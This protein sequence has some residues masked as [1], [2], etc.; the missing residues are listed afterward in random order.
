MVIR[1][2]PLNGARL[3][4]VNGLPVDEADEVRIATVEHWG[5]PDSAVYLDFRMAPSMP[6]LEF[7]VVEH[8]LRPEELL[9]EEAFARPPEYAPDIVRWSDRALLRT[10]VRL[11]LERGAVNSWRPT[12]GATVEDSPPAAGEPG[13]ADTIDAA[14]PAGGDTVSQD[15]AADTVR[16]PLPADSVLQRRPA[17]AAPGLGSPCPAPAA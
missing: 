5:R 9:G 4:A 10:P 17:E 15:L 16:G 13:L 14:D 8:L 1:L 7:A 3:S 6:L 2:P 11:S 12:A